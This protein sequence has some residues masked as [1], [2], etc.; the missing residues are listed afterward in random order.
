MYVSIL[1][2]LAFAITYFLH[3]NVSYLFNMLTNKIKL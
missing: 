1:I 3:L 2:K